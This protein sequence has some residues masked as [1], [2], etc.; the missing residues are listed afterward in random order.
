MSDHLIA[1]PTSIYFATAGVILIGTVVFGAL[2]LRLSG[3]RR[4]MLLVATV[5]MISMVFA[6][7]LMGLELFTVEVTA[8]GREQSIARFV[9][10][11]LALSS[12]VYLIRELIDLS[13]RQTVVTAGFLVWTPWA[14]LVS[15]VTTG[16]AESLMSLSAI[17]AYL[18]AAYILLVPQ[19]RQAR[20]VSAQRQLLFAK[21]RN[22]FVL[23]V[24]ALIL[25][26]ALSE[27]SLGLMDFFVGQIAASYTDLIFLYGIA[28]L[29]Y[30]GID[31]FREVP[32]ERDAEEPGE[33]VQP[34]DA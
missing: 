17:L 8:T 29:V 21:I 25:L 27:Q 32:V 14:S 31:V 2:A 16:T 19:T 22:L 11:T 12:L 3:R 1:S 30:T 24:G 10:Y 5:P 23:S 20:A 15:W 28:G 26:S 34:A 18:V 7:V 33:A 9:G 13:A 6:Y 4:R